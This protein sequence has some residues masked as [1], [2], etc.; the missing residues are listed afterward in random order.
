MLLGISCAAM[1]I[2]LALFGILAR[3]NEHVESTES[4]WGR[5]AFAGAGLMCIA[6]GG[7]LFFTSI[8]VR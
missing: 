2:F 4:V 6:F 1:G 3:K 5:F 8:I 7:G